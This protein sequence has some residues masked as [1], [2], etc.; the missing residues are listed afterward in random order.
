M[1][2]VSFFQMVTKKEKEMM[3]VAP[4]GKL[5]HLSFK[6]PTETL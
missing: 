4:E 3:D 6:E 5:I 2:S 1:K